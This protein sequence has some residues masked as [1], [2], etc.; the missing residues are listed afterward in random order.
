MLLLLLAARFHLCTVHV[1]CVQTPGAV[2][3]AVLGSPL[4]LRLALKGLWTGRSF[5]SPLVL[6]AVM[7]RP[8]VA[9]V[10]YDSCTVWRF[11]TSWIG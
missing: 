10:W 11:E 9:I 2:H 1:V 8:K 3:W 6:W 7:M 4:Q 5:C